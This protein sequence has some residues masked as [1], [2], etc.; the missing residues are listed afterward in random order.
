[1]KLLERRS[2]FGLPSRNTT[3]ALDC[4]FVRKTT[5][6][7]HGITWYRY[8]RYRYDTGTGTSTGTELMEWT[9]AMANVRVVCFN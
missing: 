1:M 5:V 6:G 7:R 2:S 8:I 3:H 4:E 9:D